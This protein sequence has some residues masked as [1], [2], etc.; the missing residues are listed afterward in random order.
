[1]RAEHLPPTNI[2]THIRSLKHGHFQTGSRT[3]KSKL[4]LHFGITTAAVTQEEGGKGI[5]LYMATLMRRFASICR[6]DALLY[7]G[8]CSTQ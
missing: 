1:M 7:A 4:T 2:H 5:R 6:R 3:K 8:E